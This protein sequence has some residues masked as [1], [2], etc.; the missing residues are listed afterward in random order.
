MLDCLSKIDEN[1]F[2]HPIIYLRA[3]R[4]DQNTVHYLSSGRYNYRVFLKGIHYL[5]NRQWYFGHFV[6]RVP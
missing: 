5:S 6:G 1:Y 4:N 2:C 3:L